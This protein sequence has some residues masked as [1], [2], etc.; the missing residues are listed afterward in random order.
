MLHMPVLPRSGYFELNLRIRFASAYNVYRD[1]MTELTLRRGFLMSISQAKFWGMITILAAVLVG[2]WIGGNTP[3]ARDTVPAQS[4]IAETAADV[5]SG[6]PK[7][8]ILFIGD[9]MQLENERAVSYYLAG[10]DRAV[11]WDDFEYQGYVSTWDIDTYNRF[12]ARAGASRFDPDTFNALIGYDPSRGGTAQWPID[13]SGQTSYFLTALPKWVGGSGSYAVPA[14][15]SASAATALATGYKTDEGNISWKSGDPAGGA[16]ETIAE[17][18]RR[19]RGYAIGVVSTVQFSHATPA[20]FVAHNVSRGNTTEIAREIINTTKPE[21]VIGGGH[22]GWLSGY[23]GSRELESLRNSD[24]YVLVEKRAGQNGGE[25][26]LAGAARAIEEHK[27]LFGLFGGGNG[28]FEPPVPQDTP[29]S[30]DFEIGAEDPSLAQAVTSALSVLGNDPDGF[31]LMVEQGDIDWANH[32]NNYHWMIGSMW[33]LD[34]AVR[35]AVDFVN[36]PG[37]DIDRSNTLIIITADHATGFMRLN[38][39]V[40]MT[41]GD[42]PEMTGTKYHYRYPGGEVSYGGTVHTNELVMVHAT[43]S[44]AGLFQRYEGASYPGSRIIDNTDIYR[45]MVEAAGLQE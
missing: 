10:T 39:A 32:Y 19:Q 30:P 15:D 4:E 20:A 5:P 3:S 18:L 7:H 43:G 42:L 8:I 35:G 38:P 24:E 23:I 6:F 29:G 2:W 21:V 40:S 45:V 44:G 37:D 11:V 17:R 31:F 16:L 26:L 36:R 27:R 12:A 28:C 34:Q 1:E 33:S 14:T 9:G 22:P 41:P 13:L 25:S